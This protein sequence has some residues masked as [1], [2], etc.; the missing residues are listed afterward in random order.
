MI[1]GL[2]EYMRR[3]L[4]K[5][6]KDILKRVGASAIERIVQP[7]WV[8]ADV[9]AHIGVITQL[10]ARLVGPAG[11]VVA[12]EAHPGNAQLLRESVRVNGYEKRVKVENL[13]VSDGCCDRLWLFPGRGC[14]STEWNIVGHDVEGNKMEPVMEIAATSLDA[15]FPAGSRLNFVKVDVEGAE[16][17]VL[18][19]MRRLLR[20]SRPVVLVEFHDEVG[21]AGR[22]ELFE[23]GYH[24]YDMSGRQLDPVQDVQRIYHC[25]AL[26]QEVQCTKASSVGRSD[27]MP[28]PQHRLP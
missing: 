9:G 19:G 21:W 5:P 15:Y 22:K 7:G 28:H 18:V 23:A 2:L 27:E 16:A 10:L 26:P 13:A 24:V 11:L 4:P 25:L 3:Y 12:F 6:I 14:S 17:Q 8:C 1:Y 20:E